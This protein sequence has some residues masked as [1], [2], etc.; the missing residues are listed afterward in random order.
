MNTTV[1]ILFLVGFVLLYGAV[2]NRSPLDVVKNALSRQPVA[3]ATPI[4]K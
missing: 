4:Q 3:N 2:K 1:L